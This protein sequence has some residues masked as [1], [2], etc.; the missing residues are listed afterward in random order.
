MIYLDTETRSPANIKAGL[1]RYAEQVQVLL[2]AYAVDDAPVQVWD[3][4]DPMPQDLYRALAAGHH[5][6]AH[7]APFDQRVLR[8]TGLLGRFYIGMDRW[9]CTEAQ[10]LAHSLPGNLSGLAQALG[11]VN[12]YDGKKLIRLFQTHTPESR[13]AEWE[14]FKQYAAQDVEVMRACVA[15]MPRWNYPGSHWPNTPGQEYLHW[16]H[17]W[18]INARGMGVDRAF[19]QAAVLLDSSNRDWMNAQVHDLTQGAVHAATQRDALLEYLQDLHLPDLTKQTVQHALARKDL[20]PKQRELLELRFQSAQN[21]A[22][23]YR[24]MLDAV[25]T[26]GRFRFGLR[27]CGAATTGRDTGRIF[28]PQNLKRPKLKAKEVAQAIRQ[29]TQG[30]PITASG[31]VADILGDCVRGVVCAAPGYKLVAADLSAV[32]ARVLAWLAD[33]AP[34]VD[35]FT[36]FDRGEVKYDVYELAYALAFSVDPASVT[37]AQR[38]IGKA[39]TLGLGF[40]GGVGAYVTFAKSVGVDLQ[41]MTVATQAVAEPGMWQNA[42]DKHEWAVEAGFDGGLSALVFAACEYLKTMWRN[43]RQPTVRLWTKLEEAVGNAAVTEGMP[44]MAGERIA[45]RRVGEWTQ[46]RLPSGRFLTL[47][48]LRFANGE[49]QCDA[50]DEDTGILIE[51][52]K[53]YGGKLAGWVTQA[54]ARDVLKGAQFRAEAAGFPIVLAVHDELVAETQ[55]KT[56]EELCAVLAAGE[57]WTTGLPL[58][59]AGWTGERYQK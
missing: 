39:M 58:A 42:L 33:D 14:Q 22:A 51:G 37:P 59:A 16:L 20:T 28:Q 55:D 44:F 8:A 5:L 43:S 11:V 35:Y 7:N 25:S 41:A 2:L 54:T 32:E 38:Q 12:K 18:Q 13:P 26:D 40:G 36:R 46:I 21:T 52:T 17:L 10:A 30:R 34:V 23:K 45:V 19:A 4:R 49:L 29:I 50:V 27:Y 24:A 57:S 15:K 47:H 48:N 3:T 1:G 56:H 53:L 6:C 9:I 31:G